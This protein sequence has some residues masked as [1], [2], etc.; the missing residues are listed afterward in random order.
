VKVEPVEDLGTLADWQAVA[1]ACWEHDHVALPADPIQERIPLLDPATPD[2][3]EKTLL[4][5]GRVDGEPVGAIEL[6]VPTI[7]NLT[8]AS[9]R[10]L[11]LPQLRHRGHGRALLSAALDETA[12]MGRRR[13]FFE[14]P[15]PYP[16]GPGPAEP[17]LRSVGARPV[18]KEVRRLLDLSALPEVDAPAPDD[19]HV[20]Q[21]V[22]RAPDELVDGLA[23]LAA[24]MS[25]D[26]PL[27]EM[28]WEP[29]IWDAGRYREKEAA[30]VARGRIRY[31]TAAVHSRTGVVTAVTDIGVSRQ[32]PEVAYQWDT[33]VLPEHR[34][35]GLGMLVKSLNHGLL[36]KSEPASRWVNTWNA[37][38]NTHMIGINERLGFRPVDCWTEWQLDR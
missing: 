30:A 15:S 9:I 17:L 13:L 33:I 36:V 2:A 18:L 5:L 12:A 1:A 8:T 32:R 11:V 16:S 23:H 38:V 37:E 10:V 34:G 19:Y 7:D 31:A 4:R 22:D 28:D 20:V 24:R 35:H 25:T 29:E 14:V 6:D 21:W 27:G 26:A 3:G